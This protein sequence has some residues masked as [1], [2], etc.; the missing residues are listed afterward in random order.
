MTSNARDGDALYLL[1]QG[2]T[3]RYRYHFARS[4]V[5]KGCLRYSNPSKVDFDLMRTMLTDHRDAD[6]VPC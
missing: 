3:D 4:A 2:A 6:E 5:G 1:K